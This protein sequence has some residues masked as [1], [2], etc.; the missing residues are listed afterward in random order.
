MVKA[1][2]RPGEGTVEAR[3]EVTG[4]QSQLNELLGRILRIEEQ[5]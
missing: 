5:L 1:R 2:T 3:R 4:L